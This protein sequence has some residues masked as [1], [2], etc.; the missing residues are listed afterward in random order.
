[1]KIQEKWEENRDVV[2]HSYGQMFN[3]FRRVSK[4][5][6]PESL[7][8][9]RKDRD[10]LVMYVVKEYDFDEKTAE[11]DIHQGTIVTLHVTELKNMEYKAFVKVTPIIDGFVSVDN[12][13]IHHVLNDNG[14]VIHHCSPEFMFMNFIFCLQDNSVIDRKIFI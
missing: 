12:S 9:I 2:I 3:M 5:E 10:I 13:T 11:W 4:L 14:S 8:L 7:D 6:F 1:M